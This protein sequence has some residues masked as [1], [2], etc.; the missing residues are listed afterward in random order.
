MSDDLREEA[1]RPD[2]DAAANPSENE[3][4][5]D[6]LLADAGA[7]A[8]AEDVADQDAAAETDEADAELQRVIE[9]LLFS[10][11]R[12][13]TARR[14]AEMSGAKDG[15]QVRTLLRRLKREYD[16]QG[17]AFGVEEIAGGFQ[18]LTRPEYAMWISRLHSRQQS[19][20]LSKAALETLA[21][22]A[23]RQPIT[24]AEVDDIRGVQC[25]P[26]LRALV[27]RRLI[28]VVG[29]AE[30]LGRPLLYGTTR[31]FLE[32]FGLK[33]LSELPKRSEF[34]AAKPKPAGGKQQEAAEPA[35]EP[36]PDDEA[37]AGEAP[38][39]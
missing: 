36:S 7:E 2:G 30:E 17:R 31:R 10:S 37:E 1:E 9:A 26:M 19:D 24:R 22:V 38:A 25:G 6:E 33:S 29:R 32:V 28:K 18:L 11:D 13:V 16:E 12:P 4:A 34:A 20:S 23:Y 5:L 8:A 15:R 14:L 21:I 3:D 27:D 39:E 35:P